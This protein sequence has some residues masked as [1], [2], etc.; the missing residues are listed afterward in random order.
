MILI[1]TIFQTRFRI[2][3]LYCRQSVF[4]TI[5]SLP[6]RLDSSNGER[7]RNGLGNFSATSFH[8]YKQGKDTIPFSS[9][10]AHSCVEQSF[11]GSQLIFGICCNGTVSKQN[12]IW[13]I[14]TYKRI[15]IT[16]FVVSNQSVVQSG[17]KNNICWMLTVD[18]VGSL[19]QWTNFTSFVLIR[20]AFMFW[21]YM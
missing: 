21:Q 17:N 13:K 7:F 8:N 2:A 9:C 12:E 3:H 19:N 6:T 11:P 4:L 20:G 18:K 1:F 10:E 16:I 14:N 15:K 5:L